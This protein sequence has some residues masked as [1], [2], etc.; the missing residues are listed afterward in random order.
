M[1]AYILYKHLQNFSWPVIT[2]TL[3]RFS[4]GGGGDSVGQGITRT[5]HANASRVSQVSFVKLHYITLRQ[6]TRAS[7]DSQT[8]VS[9]QKMQFC[10]VGW[11]PGWLAN[12][13]GVWLS[14]DV[15]LEGAGFDVTLFPHGWENNLE[16]R[17][18]FWPD[19]TAWL[20]SPSP[21]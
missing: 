3:T 19:V 7:N 14:H 9:I 11:R 6:N 10:V 17:S 1:K 8:C 5:K 15:I 21:T 4:P 12:S 20:L 16:P 13:L 18:I 2:C